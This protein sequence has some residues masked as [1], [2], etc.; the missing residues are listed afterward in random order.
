MCIKICNKIIL[1]S[2]DDG[3]KNQVGIRKRRFRITMKYYHEIYGNID[4]RVAH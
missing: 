2:P 4:E 1:H 3:F